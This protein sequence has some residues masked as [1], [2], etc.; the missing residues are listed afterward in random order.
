ML[1]ISVFR[2]ILRCFEKIINLSLK[3]NK[4]AILVFAILSI[5]FEK[6]Y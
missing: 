5:T 6:Y 2:F 3:N 1:F 4:N